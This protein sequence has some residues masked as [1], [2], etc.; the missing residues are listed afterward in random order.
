M[1]WSMRWTSAECCP[2]GN[3]IVYLIVTALGV[4]SRARY[5]RLSRY[6]KHQVLACFLQ[7]SCGMRFGHFAAR[8][9]TSFAFA[10]S[11]Q[12]QAFDLMTD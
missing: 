4:F 6:S 7:H 8:M 1:P 12:A 3:A 2:L 9:Y 10:W 5:M 11:M